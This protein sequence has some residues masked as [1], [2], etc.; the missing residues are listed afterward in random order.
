MNNPLRPSH[1]PSNL[2]GPGD[3]R[4]TALQIIADNHL[5]NALGDK[6]MLVTGCSSGLGVETVRALAATGAKVYATVRNL[7][8]GRAALADLL[9]GGKGRAR[10]ELLELD[11]ADF[12]S[13][14]RCAATFLEREEKLHVLVNNAG[15]MAIPQREVTRDGQEL[16]FQ[17]NHLG[18]FLLFQLLKPALL[19][20]GATPGFHS[21]VVNVSSIG[22]RASRVMFDDLTL[23]KPGAY[24]PFGAY[25]QSKTA[26]IYMANE[27][28]RRYGGPRGV[29]HAWSL[30]PGGIATGLAVHVDFSAILALPEVQRTTKSVEQGAATTVL[31]AVDKEL[32]GAGGKFLDDCTVAPQV[33]GDQAE[34]L[35]APGHAEWCYD[36]G[37]AR[38]LWSVSCQIV[39][40]EDDDE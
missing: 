13:V 25:G 22:H 26:N 1:L 19:R 35:H 17:T 8:K 27:I 5:E 31:A 33:R 3:S 7:S 38:R 6:V 32:E 10:V 24:T 18:H 34:V 29:L 28:E 20:G 12:A 4:P 21:R 16:Q 39:G 15:V 30:H 36:V 37:E 40:V 14:R 2:G 23:S 9:D 11:T